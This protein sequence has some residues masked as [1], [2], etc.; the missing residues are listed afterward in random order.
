MKPIFKEQKAGPNITMSIWC[1][2]SGF[3]PNQTSPN[4]S[5][6]PFEPV[7][8]RLPDPVSLI[9]TH[10]LILDLVPL[11]GALHTWRSPCNQL[12]LSSLP[13]AINTAPTLASSTHP[14]SENGTILLSGDCSFS[15]PKRCVS[16]RGCQ[17]PNNV[18]RRPQGRGYHPREVNQRQPW[19]S[20]M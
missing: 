13:S 12:K 7:N 20:E 18:C 11:V 1:Q 6:N 10:L 14:S 19:D 4:S 3:T 17:L 15:P 8:L 2:F 5:T 16:R 9:I